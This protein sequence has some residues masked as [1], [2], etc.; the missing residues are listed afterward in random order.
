MRVERRT[1]EEGDVA[2]PKTR[3]LVGL[4]RPRAVVLRHAARPEIENDLRTKI[5]RA[6]NVSMRNQGILA[7]FDGPYRPS[8]KSR[9]QHHRGRPEKLLR[10]NCAPI[11]SR[12]AG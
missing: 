12:A 3:F 8:W 7:E 2:P 4:A 9:C 10:A 11:C 5:E 6:A 1:G